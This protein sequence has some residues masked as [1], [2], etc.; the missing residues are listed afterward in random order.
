M[1]DPTV[2]DNSMLLPGGVLVAAVSKGCCPR[3]LSLVLSISHFVVSGRDHWTSGP[4][5][6]D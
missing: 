4:G 5:M 3:P 1:I 6:L 2:S